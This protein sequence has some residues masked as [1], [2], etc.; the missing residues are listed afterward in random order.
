MLLF[1]FFLTACSSPQ[2]QTPETIKYD[3][4]QKTIKKGASFPAYELLGETDK[5]VLSTQF[6]EGY[7]FYMFWASSC[8][9]CIDNI[10]TV[11]DMRKKGLWTNIEFVS[12]SIEEEQDRWKNFLYQYDMGDYMTNVWLG[13]DREHPL[14]SFLYEELRLAGSTKSQYGYI[15]PHYCLVKDGVIKNNDPIRPKDK[16]K[17]LAQFE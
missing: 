7:V 11:R 5:P 4:A 10:V 1:L 8:P 13:K 3:E 6:A 15:L 16:N 2:P 12:I 17:F 9:S 14:S